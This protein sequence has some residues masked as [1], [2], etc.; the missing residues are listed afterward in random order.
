MELQGKV[1][2][3][4]PVKG[5]VSQRTGN[6]WKVQEYVIE[7]HEN[8]PHKMVFSIFGDDRIQRFNVQVGQEVDVFFDIDA[9]E[10]QG[11]WFN[12]I[13]AYDVRPTDPAS[14]G[15]IPGE[16]AQQTAQAN[17]NPAAQPAQP[18]AAPTADPF[19]GTAEESGDALPF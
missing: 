13:R 3:V 12:S 17:A 6:E 14:I 7:T 9:H 2:Q 15:I 8:Y 11:R 19:S 18:Q 10:Y 16:R 5:G 1:I 4:L